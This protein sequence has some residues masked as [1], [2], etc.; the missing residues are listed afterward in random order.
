[1][2]VDYG[3]NIT[4]L[5]RF[6]LTSCVNLFDKYFFGGVGGPRGESLVD[7]DCYGTQSY[8]LDIS[9]YRSLSKESLLKII[10]CLCDN[11]SDLT[12][13]LGSKNMAKLTEAEIAIATAKGWT[14]A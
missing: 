1:M 6:N 4:T 2:F 9:N 5:D 11:A 12:L 13:R 7:F 3:G 14:V 8:S 10:D